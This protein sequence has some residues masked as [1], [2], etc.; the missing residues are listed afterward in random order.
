VAR[1]AAAGDDTAAGIVR[2]AA[3]ALAET[4]L[5]AARRT[6][7]A[8]ALPVALTG[9]LTG[10]GDLLLGPLR[11]SLADAPGPLLVR[12]PLGEPLDG[13]RLLALDQA[14]PHESHV[15]RAGRPTTTP[16]VPTRPATPP[17]AA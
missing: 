17:A 12:A 2:R 6:G 16:T 15:V 13:A 4:A 3:A 9:G 8:D 7:G 10:L 1:A 11:A 5:T 14:L